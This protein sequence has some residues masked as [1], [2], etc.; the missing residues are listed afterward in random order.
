MTGIIYILNF[1]IIIFFGHKH[2]MG[3]LI[4]SIRFPLINLSFCYFWQAIIKEENDLVRY[5]IY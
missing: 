5:V 3:A 2:I 4:C 1:E